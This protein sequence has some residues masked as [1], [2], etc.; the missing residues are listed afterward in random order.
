MYIPERREERLMSEGMIFDLKRFAVHDGEGLRSTLFLKGCPLRCPWCQN[1]EGLTAKPLLW[2]APSDCIHC[3]SCVSACSRK[4]LVLDQRIHMDRERCSLCGDCGR[5][6]PAGAL[7]VR[8]RVVSAREI[9]K[10]LLRDRVFF[11]DG[12]GVTLS[13]GECLLQWEF[14]CEVLGEC[15]KAGVDTA[16]ETCLYAPR[17]AIDAMLDV[18][19][20]FL[21]DIKYLDPS[22]HKMVIGTDNRL[23]LENFEYLVS[24]HADVLV[25][26]PLI[27]G[28]TATEDNIRSIARYIRS[29]DPCA[30]Y[31]LLN[32]NPLCRSKYTALEEDYP[33]E[34]TSPL[35]GDEM[36]QFYRILREEGIRHV[37]R[38]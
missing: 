4:A 33:V 21:I 23:I 22:E 37:I 16:V 28:F 9:A 12:G 3:G 1:P 8:G 27:P 5:T 30:K 38:E 20:H 7:E 36:E 6:C 26:T 10:Q 19:D 34:S 2:Y 15:R 31:E 29:V 35:T 32:Y 25:R 17:E 13:G 14:A 11:T 18:T 24:R